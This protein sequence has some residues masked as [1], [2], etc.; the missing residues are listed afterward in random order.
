[1]SV[2]ASQTSIPGTDGAA[3]ASPSP[4][5]PAPSAP[6]FSQADLDAAN[7]RAAKA[8]KQLASFQKRIDDGT[9]VREQLGKLLGVEKTEDPAAVIQRMTAEV[10]HATT[11]AQEIEA[12]AKRA[13]IN[14]HLVSMAGSA[15]VRKE[16]VEDLPLFVDMNGVEVDMATGKLANPTALA[17]RLNAVKAAKPFLFDAPA[18][19]PAP[20][21]GRAPLPGPMPAPQAPMTPTQDSTPVVINSID[22]FIGE[23][24]KLDAHIARINKKVAV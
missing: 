19:A 2:P 3:N 9:L 13:L 14:A 15:G 24:K 12:T 22:A 6:A 8:E 11:R 20:Q 16:A 1:M 4:P 17:E 7:A 18:A 23:K 5:A 21:S 10:Q